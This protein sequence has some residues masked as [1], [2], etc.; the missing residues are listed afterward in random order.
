MDQEKKN[1]IALMRYSVIAPL[2]TGLSD[3]YNSLTAFFNHASAKGVM[4]PDGTI[5]HYAPGTIERWYRNYKINGFDSLIPNGRADLGKPRR[6][7]WG[8]Q[9]QIKYLKTNYPR[10]SASAIYRQL[11][12]NGSIK[13]GEVSESTVNRYVNLLALQAKT[14]NNQD[15]RRYERPHINEVWCGDTSVGPYLKTSD[16]KKHKVF[17]IALID[18]AS[19]FIV[20][21][22]VFFNDNFINLMSVMKSAVAKYGRPQIFNFDNGSSFKNKQMEL[23]AA[24]IGSV[25]HYDQPY[26]PTQKAKI[27]RWFRTMKDQ[28][29]SSLDIREFHSLDELRGNLLAYVH[30]YNQTV[31][32]SLNGKTPQ[33]RFFSE[34][35]RIRRLSDEQI[36][37]SFLL[38]IERRVSADSVIVIDQIEYEVD[39]RFAKQRIKLRYSPDFKDIF[40]VEA[41]GTLTPIRLLN[42]TENAFVKREK[43]HLCRGEE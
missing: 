2:I 43:I 30:K 5:K 31:H 38:E 13:Y 15:M 17:I 9:E 41:D 22:D 29:M 10:M 18:D 20:G 25:I 27:E 26:T 12:D 8:L 23:L 32:S 35:E 4:H 24:R 37:S 36:E 14:T 42:K 40:I 19:R 39:C 28:W 1:A 6:L 11:R 21:I 33:D 34:S 16:G 7:D 3:D